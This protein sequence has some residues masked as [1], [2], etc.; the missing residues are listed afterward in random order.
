MF[1]SFFVAYRL[2][3]SDR[4]RLFYGTWWRVRSTCD[5]W[6][7]HSY[8]RENTNPHSHSASRLNEQFPRKPS[9]TRTVYRWL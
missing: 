9:A 7:R 3:H 2:M 1:D 8:R 6:C 5:C 4:Q